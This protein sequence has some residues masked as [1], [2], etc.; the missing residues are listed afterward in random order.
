MTE[1]KQPDRKKAES[2]DSTLDTF[3]DSAES[4]DAEDSREFSSKPRGLV[5]LQNIG[6][7]CYMNSALQALSNIP[8]LSEYFLNCG[9]IITY[10]IGDHKK[11]FIKQSLSLS[12]LKL[13][14]EMWSTE[15]KNSVVPHAI[16]TGIR[17]AHPMFRGKYFTCY[18]NLSYFVQINLYFK[19][20]L[21]CRMTYCFC[22]YTY[23]YRIFF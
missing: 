10:V 17:I 5:G 9:N 19:A 1:C 21:N 23:E 16:L 8:P 13:I 14:K 3:Q 22:N 15:P 12:Y 20:N 7:T 18:F 4:S 2:F 11:E 6:N